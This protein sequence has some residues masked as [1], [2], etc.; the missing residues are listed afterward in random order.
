MQALEELREL[1]RGIHPAVL[2]ERGLDYAL[3]TLAERAPVEV[4]LDVDLDRRPPPAIEAAAYYVAAEALANVAKYAQATT[5]SVSVKVDD[6]Q[7][8]LEVADDG[9][10]GADPSAGSGLRGLDDR[11]QAFGGS[12]RV[13]SRPGQGTRI[14]AELPLRPLTRVRERDKRLRR[15]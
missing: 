1:A 14:L 8:R 11:V 3:R 2:T 13:L 5:A 4:T 15:S 6:D 7:L 9:V 12:L 10:G